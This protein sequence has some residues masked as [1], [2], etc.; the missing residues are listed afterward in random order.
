MG[1]LGI[2]AQGSGLLFL[3]TTSAK[4]LG[5]GI[6]WQEGPAGPGQE[7][8]LLSEVGGDLGEGALILPRF[9]SGGI[10]VLLPG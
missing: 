1:V 3:W 2:L 7:E 9:Y 8:V 10:I 4:D 5:G 6:G